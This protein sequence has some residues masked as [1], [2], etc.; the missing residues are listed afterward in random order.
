M[1][2]TFAVIYLRDIVQQFR[3]LK[4]LADRAVTQ[5]DDQ[6]WFVT[7]YDEANSIAIILKHIA[8][9]MRSRWTDFFTADGEKPDRH[10][11]TEFELEEQEDKAV[12]LARWEAGWRILFDVL[13]SLTVDDL[14]KTITIR[15]EP[16]A[17][18]QAIHR[19]LSHYAYHVG[20]LVFLCKCLK[21]NDWQSLSIPRA[22]SNEF[23][24]VM[25]ER[26]RRDA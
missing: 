21:G 14:D 11:D 1:E 26:H 15:Q 18:P 9:N 19:Q 8:G 5:L 3:R 12:I 4:R 13:E 24:Q 23:N 22:K 20:Q 10:R 7:L 2:N 16:H 6:E 25:R 17:V